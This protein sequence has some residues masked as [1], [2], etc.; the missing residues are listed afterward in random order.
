MTCS[1][2]LHNSIKYL[3]I[4]IRDTLNAYIFLRF[5]K[6]H[7]PKCNNIPK[8][9]NNFIHEEQRSTTFVYVNFVNK[10]QS[11]IVD[12]LICVLTAI[13]LVEMERK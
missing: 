8:C 2:E 10:A 6:Y 1:L 9:I 4:I 13:T 5:Y 7:I 3:N 11:R 12:T